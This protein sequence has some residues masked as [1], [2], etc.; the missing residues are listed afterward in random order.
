M[1]GFSLFDDLPQ[2]G[3]DSGPAASTATP[4][5][6]SA[7]S[8][9]VDMFGDLPPAGKKEPSDTVSAGA[10]RPAEELQEPAAKRAA[11]EAGAGGQAG[12]VGTYGVGALDGAHYEL[13]CTVAERRGEREDMQDTHCIVHDLWALQKDPAKYAGLQERPRLALFGVFDGHAGANA[14]IHAAACLPAM[15]MDNLGAWLLMGA[16]GLADGLTAKNVKKCLVDT[17]K[18]LDADFLVKAAKEKWKDG[19]TACVVLAV[20]DELYVANLGDSAA[21]LARAQDGSESDKPAPLKGVAVSRSHTASVYEERQRIQKAGGTVK[22]GRV[23]GVLEVSRSIGDGQFKRSGVICVPDIVNFKIS[24]H[25]RLILVGC[26]GLWN[27]VPKQ[28]AV[29]F[30]ADYLASETSKQAVEALLDQQELQANLTDRQKADRQGQ[31]VVAGRR[32]L[33]QSAVKALVNEAVRRG[34]TDNVSVLLLLVAGPN[35]S[36]Q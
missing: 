15:L 32:M 9:A 28:D 23:M 31:R 14:S 3:G 7:P 18:Q 26:D 27:A 1:S 24:A 5:K 16:R 29:T 11:T 35:N 20:N 12:V 4:P 22:D 21:V 13:Y 33:A 36:S 17:Y 25:E 19:C 10:K 6:T 34:S 2:P 30:V 8:T